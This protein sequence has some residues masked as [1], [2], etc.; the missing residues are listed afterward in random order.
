VPTY[1]AQPVGITLGSEGNLWFAE[2]GLDVTGRIAS[3]SVK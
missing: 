2:N 3:F 1:R